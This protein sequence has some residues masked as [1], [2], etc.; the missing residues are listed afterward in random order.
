M[1]R[2]FLAFDADVTACAD[3]VARADPDRFRAVMAAPVAVRSVLFTLYAMNVE[4]ARAPWVTAEAMIAEMRLQW[5]R[6]VLSE[7]ASGAD[8]RRHMVATP[9]AQVLDENGAAALDALVAARRWDIYKDGFE[10]AAHF[11]DYLSHTSGLLM[12]QAARALGAPEAAET[13]ITAFGRATGLVRFLQAVPA[14]EAA[15]RVPLVDGRAAA[16]SGL[17]EAALAEILPRRKLRA[18]AG[19]GAPALAEGFQTHASLRQIAAQPGRVADGALALS[20]MR[21]AILL[22][23]WS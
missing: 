7:I 11:N 19:A 13:V 9:L 20:P 22:W 23:R 2:K 18:L 16:I 8:V 4:V 6:D 17:A 15:Q 1:T 12:W 3:L 5:W 21:A 10:D 14:L